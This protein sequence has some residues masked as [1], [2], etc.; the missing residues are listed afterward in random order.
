MN[1][2]A[3]YPG[4]FDPITNGHVEIAL[5][6]LKLFDKI[7]IVVANNIEKKYYFSLEERINIVKETFKDYK[8]IEVV[9]GDGLSAVQAQKLGARA[10]IRGLRAV[11]D[12]EY[13]C[14]FA[15]TNEYLA[16]DMEMVFLMSRKEFAFISSSHIKEINAFGGDVSSLVPL[17]ALTAFN[18]KK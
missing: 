13:E 1:R 2:I 16:P 4:S 14:Q 3:C 17:P 7:I 6:A 15:A 9:E 11:S 8:N 5:R 12:Y 18:N 10:I